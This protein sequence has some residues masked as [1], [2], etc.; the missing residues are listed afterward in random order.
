MD[1]SKT[2]TERPERSDE[3]PVRDGV[4]TIRSRV[5]DAQAEEKKE[6]ATHRKKE[7]VNLRISRLYSSQGNCQPISWL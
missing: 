3:D 7:T 1:S 5:V 2:V 4:T 6:K